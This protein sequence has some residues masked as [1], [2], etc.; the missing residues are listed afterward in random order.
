MSHGRHH[1]QTGRHIR[2]KPLEGGCWRGARW[3]RLVGVPCA[4]PGG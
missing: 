2:L 4:A 1:D 3:C